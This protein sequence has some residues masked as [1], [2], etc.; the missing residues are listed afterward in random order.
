MPRIAQAAAILP[1]QLGV[2]VANPG[3]AGCGAGSVNGKHKARKFGC[4]GCPLCFCFLHWVFMSVRFYFCNS[5]LLIFC[6][7]RQAYP[8]GCWEL[9]LNPISG[10]KEGA[11]KAI[12]ARVAA[13][14]HASLILC[15]SARV[16]HVQ[17][18]QSTQDHAG[19]FSREERLHSLHSLDSLHSLHREGVGGDASLQGQPPWVP[20]WDTGT[21]ECFGQHHPYEYGQRTRNSRGGELVGC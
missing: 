3:S 16:R 15:S 8:L 10:G 21:G 4:S 19:L 7:S 1:K 2:T 17:D 11:L 14:T 5:A 12:K 20:F 13:M 18:G 9:H 6:A